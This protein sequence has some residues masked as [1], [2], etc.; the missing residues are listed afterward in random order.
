MHAYNEGES[1]NESRA[2]KTLPIW[3]KVSQATSHKVT[4]AQ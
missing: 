2:I 3:A 1:K 4:V